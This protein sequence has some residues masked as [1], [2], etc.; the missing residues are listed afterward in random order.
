MRPRSSADSKWCGVEFRI[1]VIP[2]R[3]AIEIICARLGGHVDY[4][5]SGVSEF[6]RVRRGLNCEFLYRFG[7]EAHHGA[8]NAHARVV[9]AVSQNR[10]TA[11]TATI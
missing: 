6:C 5:A 7:R 4:A 3:D 10:C 11:G 9:D 1:A 8:R 2:E